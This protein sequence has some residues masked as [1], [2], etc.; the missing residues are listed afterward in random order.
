MDAV[1]RFSAGE[2]FNSVRADP[3]YKTVE[4]PRRQFRPSLSYESGSVTVLNSVPLSK[5][6]SATD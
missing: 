2:S 3:K 1:V 5:T 4:V 6:I